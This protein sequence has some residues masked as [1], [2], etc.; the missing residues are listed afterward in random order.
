MYRERQD[1]YSDVL[2]RFPADAVDEALRVDISDHS[3]KNVAFLF[4]EILSED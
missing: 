3:K 4:E 1:R 2:I